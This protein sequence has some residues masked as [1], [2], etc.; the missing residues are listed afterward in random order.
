[1]KKKQTILLLLIILFINVSFA[2]ENL[3]KDKFPMQIP[4]AG[5]IC[6]IFVPSKYIDMRPVDIWLPDDYPNG[7]PYDVIYMHDGQM[8]FD[9]TTTWNSQEWNVDETVGKLI[10]TKKIK[11]CIVVGVWNIPEKRYSDYFPQKVLNKIIEPDLLLT[12]KNL[13][14]GEPNADNYLKF[15]VT[16]LKPFIDSNYIIKSGCENTFIMGSSMGGLISL[17]AMCE[18]PNVFG[19]A[20]CLSIHSPLIMPGSVDSAKHKLLVNMFIDYLSFNL[21]KAN[22]RKIYMDYGDQTLDAYY[23]PYQ[24]KIDEIMVEKGWKYP[25]WETKFFPGENHS[26]EAWSKRLYIP[27]N[28]LLGF[29]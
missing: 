5:K 13:I 29:N 16:E 8:L 7:A 14:K 20:A 11:N 24:Q 1:M 4:K 9:G 12:L 10:H 2:Q 22:T 15:L 3:L 21:P 26:E 6:R 23:A 25:Y 19:G 27:L 28:F 18:Y 17:Y